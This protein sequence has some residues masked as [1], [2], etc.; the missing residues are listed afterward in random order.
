M[1]QKLCPG[2]I[3]WNKESGSEAKWIAFR[4]R[5]LNGDVVVDVNY[6]VRV[7]ASDGLNCRTSPVNGSVVMTY[8]KDAILTITKETNGWGYTGAGWVSLAYTEKEEDEDMTVETFGKL[9]NEYRA[10]LRDNDAGDWSKEDRQW[11]IDN[12][13]F[14]GSGTLPNGEP[15]YMWADLLTREQAAALFHRLAKKNGWA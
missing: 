6:C 8:P 12:G 1:N 11:A 3:G 13:L 10:T 5:V 2:I 7:T 9:W 4:D 15:N 14:E